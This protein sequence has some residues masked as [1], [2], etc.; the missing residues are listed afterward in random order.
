MVPSEEDARDDQ[1][2]RKGRCVVGVAVPPKVVPNAILV[3]RQ[4]DVAIEQVYADWEVAFGQRSVQVEV[5]VFNSQRLVLRV[6]GEKQGVGPGVP[7]HDA[8]EIN[9]LHI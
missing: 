2:R 3:V 4:I 5:G 6:E 8:L 9:A 1:V 7:E